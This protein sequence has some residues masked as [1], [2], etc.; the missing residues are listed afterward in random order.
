LKGPRPVL[1]SYYLMPLDLDNLKEVVGTRGFERLVGEVENQFFDAKSQPYQFDSGMD[2]KREF[3]KDV[4]A[5]ANAT[6]GYILIGFATKRAVV[7]AGE[8]IVEP[9]PIDQTLF[10]SDR[11]RKV[12]EEWLFPQPEA[13][14]INWVQFGGDK[15]KGIG[16]IFVPPQSDLSKPF[17]ITRAMGDKK[18]TELLIGYVER[19]LDRTEIR[20]LAEIHHALRIG[21]NLGRELLG[22]MGNIEARLDR[23]FGEKNE[24]E[25]AEK[26]QQ[27][28]SKRIGRLLEEDK[29][30]D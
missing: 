4:A 22:R 19:R 7:R 23:H 11:Y 24:T 26:K 21:L 13:I 8:E 20:T 14:G 2:A 16:V 5:F 1:L 25:T 10:D 30:G 12:L 18:S 15:A 9:R 29:T 28:L 6:G 3:A 27:L 17:L